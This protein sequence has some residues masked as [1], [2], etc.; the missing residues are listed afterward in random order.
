MA[1]GNAGWAAAHDSPSN[2]PRAARA[3]LGEARGPLGVARAVGD[4]HAVAQHH[5][6]AGLDRVLL[7]EE[8]RG[9]EA[10]ELLTA[11]EPLRGVLYVAGVVEHHDRGRAAAAVVP[12]AEPH[13]RRTDAA[14]LVAA[15]DAGCEHA[16]A[17]ERAGAAPEQSAV[18]CV[19]ATAGRRRADLDRPIGHVAHPRLEREEPGA[20]CRVRRPGIARRLGIENR[21]G[22]RALFL[23]HGPAGLGHP[24]EGLGEAGRRVGVGAGVGRGIRSLGERP[25]LLGAVVRQ[26][27]IAPSGHERG[28]AP[29]VL[30]AHDRQRPCHAL[31]PDVVVRPEEGDDLATERAD[32]AEVRPRRLE[33][34]IARTVHVLGEHRVVRGEEQMVVML[35][36]ADVA[37]R[38]PRNR[39]RS[40]H[41]WPRV[42]KRFPRSLHE[43]SLM[44][45]PGDDGRGAL[46]GDASS[47]C[48]TIK[49]ESAIPR[50]Y[51]WYQFHRSRPT[52]RP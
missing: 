50:G 30:I 22:D 34:H 31:V 49:R 12:A 10:R 9:T 3:G 7:A 14:Q 33:L 16:S 5:R 40:G 52:A 45:S 11:R 24:V 35:V 27:N 47:R 44:R 37:H 42:G 6:R 43:A 46:G 23:E 26:L 17:R 15:R 20:G 39:R 19:L 8:R 48:S 36:D 32:G 51:H 25:V 41:S 18:A 1:P 2:G 29:E 4:H 21:R 38:S 28:T 13:P